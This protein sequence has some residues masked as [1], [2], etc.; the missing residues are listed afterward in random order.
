M[1]V[2]S[3]IFPHIEPI[4]PI[5]QTNLDVVAS[6]FRDEGSN[7]IDGVLDSYTPDILWKAPLR[8]VHLVGKDAA[9]ANY[10]DIFSGIGDIK[11]TTEWRLA[12]GDRVWDRSR[13]E[14]TITGE[15]FSGLPIGHKGELVL[16]HN[17][18][19]RDGKICEEKVYEIEPDALHE[20]S[21]L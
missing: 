21:R 13:I 10:K 4:D 3:R 8:D 12:I 7:N 18:R 14:F 6:H 17:F 9:K 11:F 2:E 5:I 16:F 20:T 1:S 15:H 19:M